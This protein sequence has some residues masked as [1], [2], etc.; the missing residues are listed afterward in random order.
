MLKIHHRLTFLVV[1]SAIIASTQ[2][3]P[4]RQI[5]QM[6]FATVVLVETQDA[7]GQ[8]IS[9]GSGFVL[10]N[11]QV[12]TNCHVIAGA[13]SGFV[14][15]V[16]RSTKYQIV[17]TLAVDEVHDLVVVAATGLEAP[18]LHLAE[19]DEVAVGDKVY[20]IGNPQGL[21]GTFS[22]GIISAIRRVGGN[23]VLQM[24]APISQGS[25]GGPVLN[26]NGEVIGIAVST[27]T[28]G[29]NLN[30]A[31]PVSFLIGLTGAI[32]S[33]VVPLPS[34]GALTLQK[35]GLE[36]L[37]DTMVRAEAGDAKAQVRV[38]ARYTTNN[39]F[40][41]NDV[42]AAKWYRLAAEQGSAEGQY[43]LAMRYVLGRGV[44]HDYTQ[45]LFWA[46]LAFVNAGDVSAPSG[47]IADNARLLAG[48][49]AGKLTAEQLAVVRSMVAKKAP[50]A[51]LIWLQP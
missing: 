41:Q 39:G 14:R 43:L 35:A 12:A 13:A 29:Q 33:A 2:P 16:D 49:A 42:E 31:I 26:G 8:P 20:A 38:G 37:D 48:A 19:N 36:T 3:K 47:Q 28:G 27:F 45:A 4:P 5:A 11:G 17:G 7:H 51:H 6:A 46:S 30:L 32:T 50:N 21:E 18:G 34:N 9:I 15:L 22:E 44:P 25:S 24:T 10:G 40:P 23:R 1:F